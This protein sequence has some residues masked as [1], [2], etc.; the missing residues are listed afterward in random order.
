MPSIQR[1]ASDRHCVHHCF[2]LWCVCVCV[3]GYTAQTHTHKHS[4]DGHNTKRLLPF[5]F[6]IF[7]GYHLM[8]AFAKGLLGATISCRSLRCIYTALLRPLALRC[9]S[10]NALVQTNSIAVWACECVRLI[11]SLLFWCL[12]S[13][14]VGTVDWSKL[15]QFIWLSRTRKK[16]NVINTNSASFPF[17]FG[18][19]SVNKVTLSWW[20]LCGACTY[21]TH[22]VHADTHEHT[23]QIVDGAGDACMCVCWC[24]WI[25][26]Y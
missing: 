7:F 18:C 10:F 9:L 3:R 15:I 23:L 25:S 13:I 5:L 4:L 2:P 12:W 17:V 26:F 1:P 8:C 19:V 20:L 16:L 24:N 6:W 22:S 14:S 11:I 21:K